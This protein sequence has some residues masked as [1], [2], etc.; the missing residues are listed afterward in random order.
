MLIKRFDIEIEV[1]NINNIDVAHITNPDNTGKFCYAA[2][3]EGLERY[4]DFLNSEIQ[5]LTIENTSLYE[6][7]SC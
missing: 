4:I 3:V 2:D 6:R 7:I 5:R 1:Y